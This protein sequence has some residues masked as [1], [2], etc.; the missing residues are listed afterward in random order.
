MQKYVFC[1]ATNPVL[2]VLHLNE[3][4]LEVPLDEVVRLLLREH[5]YREFI[6]G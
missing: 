5:H 2:D 4:R 6:V 3:E 1:R